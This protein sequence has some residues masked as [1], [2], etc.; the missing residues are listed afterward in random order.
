VRRLLELVEHRDREVLGRD[1]GADR[2]VLAKAEGAGALARLNHE[3]RVQHRPVHALVGGAQRLER[4]G[5]GQR[6][7]LVL[8]REVRTVEHTLAVDG[9][10]AGAAHDEQP[11]LRTANRRDQ[12][13]DRV[14]VLLV[15]ATGTARTERH[16]DN[17]RVADDLLDRGDVVRAGLNAP[18][19]GR[20]LGAGTRHAGDLVPAS[21]RLGDDPATDHATRA[22]DRD[23][24]AV[25]SGR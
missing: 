6:L 14:E 15:V 7:R 2:L 20:K 1:L 3:G 17:V 21:R 5:D 18:D 22:I 19:T 4:L 10:P 16:G 24:H 23:L 11:R 9:Q 25:P 8:G 12:V 13:V